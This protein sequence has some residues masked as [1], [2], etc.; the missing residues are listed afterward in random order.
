[1]QIGEAKIAIYLEWSTP[2]IIVK[3][4]QSFECEGNLVR[5]VVGELWTGT[6]INN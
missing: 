1:M 2:L 5:R 4:S 6:L 3:I